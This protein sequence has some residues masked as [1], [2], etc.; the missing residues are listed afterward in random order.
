MRLTQAGEGEPVTAI[1]FGNA[2]LDPSTTDAGRVFTLTSDSASPVCTA[3]PPGLAI[4][5]PSG[6][7]G[8]ITINGIEITLGSTAYIATTSATQTVVANLE[9]N[10]VAA[11]PSINARVALPAGMQTVVTVQNG[12]AVAF[13]A[14]APSSYAGSPLLQ[15]LATKGLPQ[16]VDPNS[17]PVA[18][19]PACGAPIAFG[20][21]VLQQNAVPGQECIYSF[22]ANAGDVA[23]VTMERVRGTLDPYLDLRN[24]DRSLLK[25]NDDSAP[26]NTNSLICNQPLPVSGCGY[27]IVARAS[28]N[29]SNGAFRVTLNGQSACK[30]PPPNCQVTPNALNLRSGPG[31]QYPRIATL[32]PGTKLFRLAGSAGD[33]WF[34]VRVAPAGA[35][36]WITSDTE[37]LFCDDSVMP[38]PNQGETSGNQGS[39]T[40]AES[41][42]P[43]PPP[44]TPFKTGP[45]PGP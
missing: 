20:Q 43:P 14:P 41:P 38:A 37:L 30:A 25:W 13:T 8:R 12:V 19:R 26:G 28:G 44:P 4:R 32:A 39:S 45:F 2:E 27:T 35:T 17:Q 5:V 42:T 7:T 22:C 11:L 15:W 21:T 29:D 34:Q 1:L 31:A 33:L 23:T 40:P 16:V 9:G 36:G 3:T 10:V 18:G 6:K 24:P